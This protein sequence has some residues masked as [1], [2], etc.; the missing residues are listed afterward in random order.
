MFQIKELPYMSKT[1]LLSFLKIGC[2]CGEI[3]EVVEHTKNKKWR[4]KLRTCATYL[5]S[6][7]M[8]RLYLLDK[9][10]LDSVMRRK[11]TTTLIM[12]TE[13]QERIDKV[14]KEVVSVDVEDLETMAELALCSC[15]SCK[16]GDVVADCRFRTTFHR[17]GIPVCNCNPVTGKCEFKTE[18]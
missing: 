2:L 7:I 10:Q 3:E 1:E 11:K 18:R 15:I 4:Q 17:L 12:R 16:E 9:K 6:I 5:D 14:E 13:D 8:E